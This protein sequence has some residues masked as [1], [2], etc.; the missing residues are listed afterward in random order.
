MLDVVHYMFE[1]DTA[2]L[3]TAEQADAIS[4]MRTSV[5]GLYSKSYKYGTKSTSSSSGRKYI[6]EDDA[7]G[8][9]LPVDGEE[10]ALKPFV[11][12]TEFNPESSMPFGGVLD[13]PLG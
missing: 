5:Y 11:P 10:L 3:S 13:A 2:R 9:G 12:P 1:E 4:S 6:T 7:P 8:L